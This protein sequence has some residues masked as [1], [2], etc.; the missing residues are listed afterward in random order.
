MCHI[1]TYSVIYYWADALQHEIYLFYIITKQIT[2]HK[3]FVYFKILQHNAK[4]CLC[5]L[6]GRRKKAI[7]RNLLSIQTEAILL[8]TMRCKESVIGRGK[9]RHCQTWLERRSLWNEN[10]QQKHNWTAKSTNLEESA[11]K[12]KLVF[13]IGAALWARACKLKSLDVALKIAGVEKIP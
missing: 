5:P 1:L 12:I 2:T 13:V 6:W 11:G 8:V 4:A 7:W 3:V 10:L 9:S